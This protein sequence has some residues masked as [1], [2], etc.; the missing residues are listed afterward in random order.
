[1]R[2]EATR[3]EGTTFATEKA[4]VAIYAIMFLA[5]IGMGVH[6]QLS[7]IMPGDAELTSV[8]SVTPSHWWPKQTE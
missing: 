8:A 5:V 7:R 6:M 3:H 4:L 1:M 2:D